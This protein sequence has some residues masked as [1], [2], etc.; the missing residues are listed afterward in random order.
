MAAEG[1]SALDLHQQCMHR[2]K[3]VTDPKALSVSTSNIWEAGLEI[4]VNSR[5]D[6]PVLGASKIELETHPTML[7]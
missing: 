4:P 5:P 2:L 7:L 6:A 3:N 1:P